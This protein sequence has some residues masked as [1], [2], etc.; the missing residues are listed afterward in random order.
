ME[1]LRA[2]G[3][4]TELLNFG[5]FNEDH[6]GRL[7][8]YSTQGD[9]NEI[10]ATREFF[11][12]HLNDESGRSVLTSAGGELVDR[13][14]S[15]R[16]L[17]LSRGERVDFPIG[18]EAPPADVTRTRFSGY[19]LALDIPVGTESP[20]RGNIRAEPTLDLFG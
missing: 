11:L 20:G 16:W 5:R 15:G 8:S 1:S 6:S 9:A 10:V 13:G 18:A 7:V 17:V 12:F 4:R 14:E 2:S 3:A 19:E